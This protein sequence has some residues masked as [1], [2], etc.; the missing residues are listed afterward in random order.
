MDGPPQF[1]PARNDAPNHRMV[2]T[3]RGIKYTLEYSYPDPDHLLFEGNLEGNAV[4]IRSRKMAPSTFP[5]LSRG[6]H[7]INEQAFNR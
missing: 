7:W 5:L 2:L 4:S 6:F 3:V 1:F